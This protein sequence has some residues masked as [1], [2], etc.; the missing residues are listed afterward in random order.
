MVVGAAAAVG[1]ASDVVF[2][3]AVAVDVV[4]VVVVVVVPA[5][6]VALVAAVVVAS[7]SDY[8]SVYGIVVAAAERRTFSGRSGR[9]FGS[10][11]QSLRSL[12]VR[13]LLRSPRYQ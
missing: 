7:A 13:T 5:V 11:S 3:S 10:P 4:V 8:D 9:T 6:A 12:I 1:S 2:A